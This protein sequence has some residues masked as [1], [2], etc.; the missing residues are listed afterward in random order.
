[1]VFFTLTSHWPR[2]IFKTGVWVECS[3]RVMDARGKFGERRGS[4]RGDRGAAKR[5]LSFLSAL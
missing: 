3:Y 4:L 1:M 2:L 5:N